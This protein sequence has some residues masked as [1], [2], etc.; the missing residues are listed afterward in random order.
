MDP[1]IKPVAQVLLGVAWNKPLPRL[2]SHPTPPYLAEYSL[3]IADDSEGF[4]HLVPISLSFFLLGAPT[5][6]S[7]IMLE[8]VALESCL[9]LQHVKQ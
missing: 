2:P 9:G 3:E 5:P 8:D 6:G 4:R 1:S 7:G